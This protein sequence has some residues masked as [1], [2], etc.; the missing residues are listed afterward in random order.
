MWDCLL[1][2]GS[3]VGVAAVGDRLLE[4]VKDP[5]WERALCDSCTHGLVALLS[6]LALILRTGR[7]QGGGWPYVPW[8]EVLLCGILGSAI[9]IDHFIAARSFDLKLALHLNHRPPLHSTGLCCLLAAFPFLLSWIFRC[10]WLFRFGWLWWVAFSSHHLRD[11]TRRGL[12]LLPNW[13]TPPLP[14]PLYLA[15]LAALPHITWS[16]MKLTQTGFNR[17]EGFLPLRLEYII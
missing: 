9:D 7:C 12:W 4:I 5:P 17:Q 8:L 10:D 14:R 16:V 2:S 1:V 11:G 15:A 3:I 6:W 13:S